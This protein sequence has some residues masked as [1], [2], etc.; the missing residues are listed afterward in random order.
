MFKTLSSVG[1]I[2]VGGIKWWGFNLEDTCFKETILS[3]SGYL[4]GSDI[5]L[6]LIQIYK[7]RKLNVLPNLVAYYLLLSKEGYS[8]VSLITEEHPY[9]IDKTD[10]S[11][12]YY[13]LYRPLLKI[14]LPAFFPARPKKKY[15]NE[16]ELH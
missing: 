13:K 2:S 5:A 12:M 3:K 15:R 9:F 6:Q 16:S 1:Q 14:R 10:K 8:I 7:K 11:I 4:D